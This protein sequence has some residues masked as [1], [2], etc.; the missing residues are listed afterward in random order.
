[1]IESLRILAFFLNVFFAVIYPA[2]KTPPRSDES[3]AANVAAEE[4]HFEAEAE[5]N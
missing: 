2:Q 5:E 1:M 3:D 4:N